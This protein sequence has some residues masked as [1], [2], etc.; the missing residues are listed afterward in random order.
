MASN[1][2]SEVK[3]NMLVSF[4]IPMYNAEPYIENTVNSIMGQGI[5]A[6]DYEIIIVN[7]GSK[8]NS[9]EVAQK[10]AAN[11]E[12]VRVFTQSNSG[13]S[14]ARNKGR[15][16][17]RG[18]YLCFVDADDYF[19]PT[20]LFI[21]YKN[22]TSS[23]CD[24]ISGV[25]I[26]SYGITSHIPGVTDNPDSVPSNPQISGPVDGQTYIGQHNY[27]NGIGYYWINKNYLDTLGLWFMEGSLCEDGIFTTEALLRAKKIIHFHMNAYVY[28]TRPDSVT[29]TVDPVRIRKIIDGFGNAVNF[30]EEIIKNTEI[31]D[32]DC[33]VR[34]KNRQQSYTFFLLMRLLR[35]GAAQEAK[36]TIKSLK[37]IG[38]YPINN[39]L[40]RDYGGSKLKYILKIVNRQPLFLLGCRL[41]KIL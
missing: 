36:T 2:T 21:V 31:I 12:N 13:V 29:T 16:E 22:L 28:V 17:A 30:F 8:D 27:N 15:E 23:T 10:L 32:K 34:L 9:L 35:N 39:L 7:D 40:G 20:S 41:K 11:F 26:I 37:A 1:E 6:S 14:R 5:P 19:I 38:Q 25:D 3:R 24:K 18:K 4:I 33:L